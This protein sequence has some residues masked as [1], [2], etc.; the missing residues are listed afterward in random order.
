MLMDRHGQ[1]LTKHHNLNEDET[2]TSW[3]VTS[4][5]TEVRGESPSG[6]DK[7]WPRLKSATA[8]ETQL[9]YKTLRGEVDTSARMQ[10]S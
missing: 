7:D 9:I 3:A 6:R 8:G 1:R 4:K 5:E 2:F 10:D